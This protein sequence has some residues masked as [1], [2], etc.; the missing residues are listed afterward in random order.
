MTEL[1]PPEKSPTTIKQSLLRWLM[2]VPAVAGR[3]LPVRLALFVGFAYVFLWVPDIDLIFIGI[4]HHRSIITHSLLPGL[5]FLLVGRSLG[6]A[7]V[8][9]ALV[10]LSVHL[11]CDMLSPMVGYAQIWL[12][13]PYKTPL[14][15]I[16]YVWLGANALLGFMAASFIARIAFGRFALA[17]VALTSVV[18]GVTYGWYNENSVL[19]VLVVLV[20]V[21]ASLLP[22]TWWRRRRRMK[23]KVVTSGI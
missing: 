1:R 19:S 10:G 8:A 23:A 13:A 22:E 16:S 6:A 2:A 9:G 11:A 12:P 21:A 3:T 4:L 5:L 18:T 7:P 20:M 15:P 14:G 17:V